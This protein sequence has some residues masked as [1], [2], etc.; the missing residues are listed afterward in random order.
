[1]LREQPSVGIWLKFGSVATSDERRRVPT[2]ITH[3]SEEKE[4]WARGW[5]VGSARAVHRRPRLRVS[6]CVGN[7]DL[8]DR[9]LVTVLGP[10][11]CGSFTPTFP[12]AW[13]TGPCPSHRLSAVGL[14]CVLVTH[15]YRHYDVNPTELTER[16]G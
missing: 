2:S 8:W 4:T 6:L 9:G 14:S 7:P 10:F 16:R 13:G 15:D 1:M 11:F 5:L 3:L 12:I